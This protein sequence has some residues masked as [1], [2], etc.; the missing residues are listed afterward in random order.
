M[1]SDQILLL[2]EEILCNDRLISFMLDDEM[3]APSGFR[4]CEVSSTNWTALSE[5]VSR[6]IG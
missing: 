4:N 2:C 1:Q 5:I 6:E 3:E